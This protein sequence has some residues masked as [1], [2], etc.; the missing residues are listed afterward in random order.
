MFLHTLIYIQFKEYNDLLQKGQCIALLGRKGENNQMF[1][2]KVKN[3]Q[4]WLSERKMI[5]ESGGELL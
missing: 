5:L 4:V 3:F 2:K 1:I